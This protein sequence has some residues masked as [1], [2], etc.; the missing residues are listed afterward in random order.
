MKDG[1]V[2]PD[3]VRLSVLDRRRPLGYLIQDKGRGGNQRG[4]Q[5][6]KCVYACRLV[7]A[8]AHSDN[9]QG[10][11]GE[12]VPHDKTGM[13]ESQDYLLF[14]E[15]EGSSRCGKRCACVSVIHDACGKRAKSHGEEV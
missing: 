7:G 14:Q 15:Q 5:Y 13:E 1:W 10:R 6:R 2:S 8:R 3:T 12:Q 4:I 11:V 9:A